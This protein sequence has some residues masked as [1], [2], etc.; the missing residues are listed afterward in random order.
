[1]FFEDLPPFTD[2]ILLADID[3]KGIVRLGFGRSKIVDVD[4]D[5]R[6]FRNQQTGPTLWPFDGEWQAFFGSGAVSRFQF[7]EKEN[8]FNNGLAWAHSTER[9]SA[10]ET[11]EC[12]ATQPEER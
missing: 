1:M 12:R 4:F 6:L 5:R 7:F 9:L 10:E 11:I 3:L 2:D 8:P